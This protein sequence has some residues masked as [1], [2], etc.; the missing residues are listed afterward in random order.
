LPQVYGFAQQSGGRV[1][2]DSAVG[3][4]TV[5]TLSLPRSLRPPAAAGTDDASSV[6]PA[7]SDERCGLVLLV[8]DDNEVAALTREMLCTSG[9]R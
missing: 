5:V 2:I 1:R 3:E 4:G 6:A 8:E 7:R 9:S